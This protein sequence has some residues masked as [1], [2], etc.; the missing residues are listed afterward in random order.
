MATAKPPGTV[1]DDQLTIATGDGA[2]R[3]LELQRAG[4][5]VLA[6]DAF[7]RGHTIPKG[8]QLSLPKGPRL[9]SPM[10]N[11]Y[12]TRMPLTTTRALLGPMGSSNPGAGMTHVPSLQP[13][14][15]RSHADVF[16]SS[17]PKSTFPEASAR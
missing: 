4:R 14:S 15:S 11:S 17:K 5:A 6:T 16:W 7:L 12:A 8:T 10:M 9:C 13:P 3:I 2:V 1:L